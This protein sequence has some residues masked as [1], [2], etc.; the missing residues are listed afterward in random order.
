MPV[1]TLVA[2]INAYRRK[3]SAV[4]T[5][6]RQGRAAHR[7]HVTLKRYHAIRK[8][9]AFVGHRWK[10]SGSWQR[11][12]YSLCRD[13]RSSPGPRSVSTSR[14]TRRAEMGPATSISEIPSSARASLKNQL[15][16]ACKASSA[17]AAASGPVERTSL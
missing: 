13:V 7:Y 17:L 1:S 12:M 10:S 14:Q 15:R 3:G 4:I 9:A 6:E 8:W 16:A 11:C 5:V 2:T